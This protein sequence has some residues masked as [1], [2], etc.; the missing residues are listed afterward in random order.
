M[1]LS[2]KQ[3]EI[4]YNIGV[5][6]LDKC[7]SVCEVASELTPQE[8]G[9]TGQRFSFL[10]TKLSISICLCFKST[11]SVKC[12][13]LVLYCFFIYWHLNQES[14]LGDQESGF[15]NRAIKHSLKT[16]QLMPTYRG[17][18]KMHKTIGTPPHTFIQPWVS[19]NK[20]HPQKLQILQ[21]H[22]GSETAHM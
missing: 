20:L 12:L 21:I 6:W 15:R 10:K 22:T 4:K 17:S 7:S 3:W 8:A 13:A 5:W 1:S 2:F 19:V 14:W 18:I 9:I 11:I 16:R